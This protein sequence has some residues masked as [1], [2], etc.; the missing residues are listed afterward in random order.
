M[1]FFTFLLC[2]KLST[3]SFYNLLWF[4]FFLFWIEL[5]S[6]LGIIIPATPPPLDEFLA[7]F[8]DVVQDDDYDDEYY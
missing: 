6:I 2:E 8:D 1:V 3:F 5:M 7:L 4:C